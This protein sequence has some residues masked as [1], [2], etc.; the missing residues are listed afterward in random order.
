MGYTCDGHG[1]SY[2]FIYCIV[3]SVHY[4]LG[5]DLGGSAFVDLGG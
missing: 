1:I 4:G 2:I 3:L 5:V